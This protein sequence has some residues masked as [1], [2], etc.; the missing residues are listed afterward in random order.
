[1]FIAVLF[2]LTISYSLDY[3]CKSHKL[4]VALHRCGFTDC[5]DYAIG[6]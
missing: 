6:K 4:F 5:V 2:Q 1:M 3:S